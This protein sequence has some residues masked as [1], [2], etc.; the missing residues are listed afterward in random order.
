M[1]YYRHRVVD[2]NYDSVTQ[3]LYFRD[4]TDESPTVDGSAV[5]QL[6]TFELPPNWRFVFRMYFPQQ[7]ADETLLQIA[8]QFQ[9]RIRDR[10][11]SK[12]PHVAVQGAWP[13]APTA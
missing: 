9:P 11:E 5:I 2:V 6:A 1:T 4:V 7:V 10:Y 12:N 3:N 13:P 8:Y